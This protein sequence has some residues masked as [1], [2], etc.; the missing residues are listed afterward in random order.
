MLENNSFQV[1]FQTIFTNYPLRAVRVEEQRFI[2]WDHYKF[3]L[4]QTQLNFAVFCASSA[5]GV[6]VEHMNVKKTNDNK[7]ISL[8]CLLSHQKDVKDT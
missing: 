2:D 6:S 3:T 4:W 7:Y 1:N 5:C 8:S